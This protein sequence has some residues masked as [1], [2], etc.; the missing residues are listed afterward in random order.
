MRLKWPND[1]MLDGDKLGGI[2]VEIVSGLAV[3]GLGVNLHWPDRPAEFAHLFAREPDDGISFELAAL[4]GAELNRMWDV[5]GW[6]REEFVARCE[7]VGRDIVWDG[8]EGHA[9]DV[10]DSG[11]LVVDTNSGRHSLTSGSVRHV[12]RR[13]SDG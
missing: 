2:L 11:A 6:D 3:V 5:P 7:T 8:G 4:W 12:R 9:V 1:L 13:E 10:D